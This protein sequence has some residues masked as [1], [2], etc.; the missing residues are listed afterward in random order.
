VAERD[1][2]RD[3]VTWFFDFGPGF[4]PPPTVQKVLDEWRERRRERFKTPLERMEQKP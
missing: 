2:L 3:T 4:S 1:A